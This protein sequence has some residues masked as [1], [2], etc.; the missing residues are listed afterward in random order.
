MHC[1]PVA[2]DSQVY[3]LA[4]L[5]DGS[6]SFDGEGDVARVELK[7]LQMRVY[8]DSFAEDANNSPISL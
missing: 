1:L 7:S 5:Q 4:S 3:S 8:A 6:F 2:A